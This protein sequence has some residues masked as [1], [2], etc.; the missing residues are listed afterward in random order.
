MAGTSAYRALAMTA[1]QDK[2]VKGLTQAILEFLGV[3]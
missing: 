3:K 2:I 1:Y